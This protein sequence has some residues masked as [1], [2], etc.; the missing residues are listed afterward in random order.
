MPYMQNKH[1]LLRQQ[2][3][4][5]VYFLSLMHRIALQHL[6]LAKNSFGLSLWQQ[7]KL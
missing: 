1:H 2:Q 3:F 6:H 4:S 7:R 5:K